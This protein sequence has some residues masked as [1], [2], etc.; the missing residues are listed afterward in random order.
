MISVQITAIRPEIMAYVYI[1]FIGF[2]SISDL[3]VFRKFPSFRSLGVKL[4]FFREEEKITNNKLRTT[5]NVYHE[6]ILTTSSFFIQSSFQA[7]PSIRY[8]N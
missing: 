3:I 2:D 5:S 7:P 1:A 6:Q 4:T 8:Y